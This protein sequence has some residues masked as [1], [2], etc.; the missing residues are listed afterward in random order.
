MTVELRLSELQRLNAHDWEED[1]S[2]TITV[3]EARLDLPGVLV[4]CQTPVSMLDN[5]EPQ[6][7]FTL[8]PMRARGGPRRLET[9]PLLLIEIADSTL[10][11]DLGKK[12]AAYA[13]AGVPEYWIVATKTRETTAHREPVAGS[14][15]SIK[16]IP[17]T[18]LLT[19]SAVPGLKVTLSEVLW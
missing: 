9:E 19:S 8:A 5:T 11:R 18:S 12:A 3:M 14:Y 4:R 13:G 2:G 16:R 1:W 7:D 6:P 15:S 10:E 17:W